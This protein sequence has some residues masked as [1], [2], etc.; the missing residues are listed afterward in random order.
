M[1]MSRIVAVRGERCGDIR[2][3]EMLLH[4]AEE[5]L[6]S[7]ETE[8][9]RGGLGGLFAEVEVGGEVGVW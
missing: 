4:V 6:R 3:K 8:G 7:L 5:S 1:V 2:E 9:F